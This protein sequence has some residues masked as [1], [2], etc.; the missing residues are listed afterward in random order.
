MAP[1]AMVAAVVAMV[2]AVS[3]AQMIPS[4]TVHGDAYNVGLAVGRVFAGQL[5][6]FAESYDPLASVLR[7]FLETDDGREAFAEWLQTNTAL[8]PDQFAEMKGLSDGSGVPISDVLLLNFREVRAVGGGSAPVEIVSRAHRL[9]DRVQEI[10][11]LIDANDTYTTA[12]R[13]CSDMMYRAHR[14]DET[15]MAH[16]EDNDASI[17]A[18]AFFLT[19][20][21]VS[22]ATGTAD[23][24]FTSYVY[25]LLT[26]GNAF[27]FNEYGLVFTVNALFPKN[28][29]V[30]GVARQC[31]TRDV[32]KSKSVGEAI[33][34]TAVSTSLT[35]AVGERARETN[36]ER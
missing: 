9:A 29:T 11:L 22:N 3:F 13:E 30:G 17:G 14:L 26:A 20:T 2:A 7:P 21:V 6:Q 24:R 25:P 33:Q 10:F 18:G 27:S 5:Q 28:V 31:L 34:R 16:N 32:L 19:A 8:Y 35:C 23:A 36:S 4:V 12:P 1:T 15:L